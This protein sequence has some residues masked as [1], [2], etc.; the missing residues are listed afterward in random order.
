MPTF[1]IFITLMGCVIVRSSVL[2]WLRSLTLVQRVSGSIP[3]RAKFL[4]PLLLAPLLH[5]TYGGDLAIGSEQ[6]TPDCLNTLF[7]HERTVLNT[8]RSTLVKQEI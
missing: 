1:F 6:A 3:D 8:E 2:Q 5:A 7:H 4:F